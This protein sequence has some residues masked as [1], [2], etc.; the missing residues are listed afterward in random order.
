[1]S[2]PRSSARGYGPSAMA[3]MNRTMSD[4]PH[5]LQKNN[6]VKLAEEKRTHDAPHPIGQVS[7]GS[8]RHG[9][10]SDNSVRVA[11]GQ[12]V[13]RATHL[14]PAETP[15]KAGMQAAMMQ[16]GLEYD[17]AAWISELDWKRWDGVLP[18]G[19]EAWVTSKMIE[20]SADAALVLMQMEEQVG[21]P[22]TWISRAD[23]MTNPNGAFVRATDD[24]MA[25]VLTD[26]GKRS[27]DAAP[28]FM[29]NT[30]F[31]RKIENFCND[32]VGH[33]PQPWKTIV[34]AILDAQPQ[35]IRDSIYAKME[36]ATESNER[37][38]VRIPKPTLAP[39]PE[40]DF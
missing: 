37:I 28:D 30:E 31:S 20:R 3:K 7:L 26:I 38:M 12:S 24:G 40:E 15:D 14:W 1:M 39:R 9:F 35:E 32:A 25:L 16:V 34:S 10:I 18:P 17:D 4:M 5:G 27:L 29:K 23:N 13:A 33:G 11:V 8:S 36:P 22:S 6:N 19:T 2:Y 21:R